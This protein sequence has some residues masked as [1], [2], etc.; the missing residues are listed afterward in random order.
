MVRLPWAKANLLIAFTIGGIIR[1]PCFFRSVSTH[2]WER[3]KDYK[4]VTERLNLENRARELEVKNI[5]QRFLAVIV[6]FV[7]R[8]L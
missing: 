8:T 5:K 3:R 4:R 2:V 1:V 7:K 6:A